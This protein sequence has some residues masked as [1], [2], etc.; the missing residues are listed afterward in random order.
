M[1]ASSISLRCSRD[2][3]PWWALAS[4]GGAPWAEPAWAIS[5]AG[6]LGRRSGSSRVGR[7]WAASAR[8]S[9]I[10]L[11]RAVSRSASRRELANT[12]VEECCSTRSTMR[13]STAGQ[14]DGLGWEPGKG[15]PGST[16]SGW[17]GSSGVAPGSAMSSTGTTTS[18]VITL[19]DTG[20][21]TTTS[22]APP[23]KRATSST[24]RT[25]A[26]RPSR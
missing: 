11:S 21:T 7:G 22:A 2:T 4:N 15:S 16:V 19:V 20:W 9:A 14:I 10:S 13:S 3:L 6:V 18:T 24:G 12:M 26:D 8:S 1:S 17:S 23:R 5:S 25:V